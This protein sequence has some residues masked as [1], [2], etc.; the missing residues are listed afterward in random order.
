[1]ITTTLQTVFIDATRAL[2]CQNLLTPIFNELQ[3][4]G[5]LFNSN[6]TV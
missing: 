3:E 1:M 4:L 2:Y 6:S 5:Y